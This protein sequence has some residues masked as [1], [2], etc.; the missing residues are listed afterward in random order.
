[1][2]EIDIGTEEINNELEKI[3]KS[4]ERVSEKS[5]SFSKKLKKDSI[6][7]ASVVEKIGK[8]PL[9]EDI[10]SLERYKK[11]V[12]E[13]RKEYEALFSIYSKLQNQSKG[14]RRNLESGIGRVKNL[15]ENLTLPIVE[16]VKPAVSFSD[17]KRID[18]NEI[19]NELRYAET[20]NKTNEALERKLQL[21]KSLLLMISQGGLNSE[22]YQQT[23]QEHGLQNDKLLNL[24]QEFRMVQ[25][26]RDLY[27]DI[28]R[29]EENRSELLELHKNDP[30]NEELA[31]KIEMMEISKSLTQQDIDDKKKILELFRKINELNESYE[32]T[33]N[34]EEKDAIT[35]NLIL[36]EEELKVLREKNKERQE[37]VEIIQ[38]EISKTEEMLK[39]F[40]EVGVEQVDTI[41]QMENATFKFGNKLKAALSLGLLTNFF[42]QLVKITSEFELQIVA[43]GAL[44]DSQNRANKLFTSVQQAALVSPYS[45]SEL[46]SYTK[47]LAAYRVETEDLTST[48]KMLGDIASGVG[49]DMSRLILVYGQ[50]KAANYLRG[51]ELRQFSEA[52]VNIL[53]ELA[54]YYSE[55]EGVRVSVGEVFERVSDR[56]V[57]FEDVQKVL[58]D[59]TSDGGLFDDMQRKQS[60]TIAGMMSNLKDAFQINMNEMGS[61]LNTLLKGAIK[62]VRFFVDNLK[63][64]TTVG[65][66]FVASKFGFYIQQMVAQARAAGAGITGF[67]NAFKGGIT[68]GLAGLAV[69]GIMGIANA[70]I[71]ARKRAEE[72][73]K[74]YNE[75]LTGTKEN[76][77][78]FYEVL[79]RLKNEAGKI[80]I[81]T[82][83]DDFVRIKEEVENLRQ[84]LYNQGLIIPVNFRNLNGKDIVSI[85]DELDAY[86]SF[87]AIGFR[88]GKDVRKNPLKRYANNI[89]ALATSLQN[90]E[91]LY[92]DFSQYLEGEELKK[93]QEL[94]KK[95]KDRKSGEFDLKSISKFLEN[96]RTIAGN[97][98][99]VNLYNI[100]AEYEDLMD[101]YFAVFTGENYI[102]KL[103][104]RNTTANLNSEDKETLKNN[105]TQYA[106]FIQS[107]F[108][109]AGVDVE[110]NFIKK[111]VLNWISSANKDGEITKELQNFV[112]N[113]LFGKNDLKNDLS[114]LQKE[115]KYS[116]DKLGSNFKIN[117]KAIM[118]VTPETTLEEG[119]KAF[120]EY[121]DKL[122]E[123]ERYFSANEEVK[124]SW[125]GR[126]GLKEDITKE[127][128]EKLLKGTDRDWIYEK[129]AIE[130]KDKKSGRGVDVWSE[131]ISS[132]IKFLKELYSEAEKQSKTFNKADVI[133]RVTE[134]FESGFE[135]MPEFFKQ[136]FEEINKISFDTPEGIVKAFDKLKSSVENLEIGAVK[137]G[138]FKRMIEEAVNPIELDITIDEKNIDKDKIFKEIDDLFTQYDL[139]KELEDLNIPR[140][141]TA[142]MF[143]LDISNF[144]ELF[145]E[146]TQRGV[147]LLN[148]Y[149]EDAAKEYKNV[150]KKLTDI[151]IKEQERRMKEYLKL[152]QDETSKRATIELEYLRK[153]QE[154]NS[155]NTDENTKLS[156]LSKVKET[157]KKELSELEW[158]TFKSSDLFVMLFDDLEHATTT[159]ID[160]ILKKLKE[161]KET[162]VLNNADANVISDI[163]KSINDLENIKIDRNPLKA[164]KE[165]RD[166]LIDTT[167][168]K[169]IISAKK[170]NDELLENAQKE[171]DNL[172]KEYE[173][174]EL[175]LKQREK[176][177]DVLDELKASIGDDAI[178]EDGLTSEEILSLLDEYE[179]NRKASDK[180][181]TDYVEYQN[182]IDLLYEYQGI[183]TKIN[184]LEAENSGI[185]S[186]DE[187]ELKGKV[188]SA[189]KTL[190][191]AKNTAKTLSD[192]QKALLNFSK[193][194]IEAL[195]VV[196]GVINNSYDLIGALGV[197]TNDLTDGWKDFM[198]T[199]FDIGKYTLEL[200]PSLIT[201]FTSA[202]VAINSAMGIIGLIAQAINLTI[203]M[204][205]V[206]SKIH[207]AN[208][209]VQIDSIKESADKLTKAFEKLDKAF[210]LAFDTEALNEYTKAMEQNLLTQ[211]T[212]LKNM[213]A[214]EKEK[215][216]S[217]EDAIKSWEE[218]ID[219]I[220]EQINEVGNKFLEEVGGLTEDAQKELANDFAEAWLSSFEEVGN[221]IQGLEETFDEFI[222]NV[223]LKQ[224]IQQGSKQYIQ[225]LAEM[226]NGFVSD[227][228]VS[229]Q[230]MNEIHD[231]WNNEI[232]DNLDAYY[233]SVYSLFENSVGSGSLSG[234]A[235]GI[236]GVTED[237]AQ[238]IESYMNSIRFFVAAKYDKIVNIENILTTTANNSIS[239]NLTLIA[240]NT[241]ALLTI[242]EATTKAGHPEGGTGFKVFIN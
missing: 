196:E 239:S 4:F 120:K 78:D 132:S 85:K 19:D 53:G 186:K 54:K 242:L 168:K 35:E 234:L 49:V 147:T 202:G 163:V 96:V 218:D 136:T 106:N 12:E 182:I 229:A 133:N 102:K 94:A 146:I 190:T 137:K 24:V 191:T 65:F 67:F 98:G 62:T 140:E 184:E 207:D 185:S 122:K 216:D 180:N 25:E 57:A 77:S 167:G 43:L 197:E 121:F 40:K 1:M 171:Y 21:E 217:D 7:I 118:T 172:L 16:S 232:R 139:F 45:V 165:L 236:Q 241:E 89:D 237:T 33:D 215:K 101:S 116:L 226:I 3:A 14:T 230:E 66:A 223:V 76:L 178:F 220:L 61:G 194:S 23:N 47:Q 71:T 70:M 63:T 75:L 198:N 5:K 110:D 152:L 150:E 79:E 72:F 119:Q 142:K 154:I 95:A 36:A 192:A 203:Q 130:E 176:S 18:E 99:Y 208:I 201:G 129:F 158:E 26:I 13:I 179:T 199:I 27:S 97:N 161:L 195:D 8:L 20:I 205:T 55:L 88:E 81:Q 68:G 126:L 38:E 212:Y 209:E 206:L 117:T 111:L 164:F 138:K 213:I 134:A 240:N 108:D 214:L 109:K 92:D 74:E 225:K 87:S 6:D 58:V 105:V 10:K 11:G 204:V 156:L 59:L 187:S 17:V 115:I 51:Q 233:Q 153:Q 123:Y 181:S 41:E 113:E 151:A 145:R 228:L 91:E 29:I 144:N 107:A 28:N 183:L 173:T 141:T 46:I 127:E 175:Y 235:S 149:G 189:E 135:E 83:S 84:E 39:S 44:V 34:I 174:L 64:V 188:D 56:R 124:K 155:L 82:D 128:V 131:R 30:E 221:G 93:F 52:G 210:G 157:Y 200:I 32:Q 114:L 2:A 211:I 238:I 48:L 193:Q 104:G 231:K 22:S 227:G 170:Y 80:E 125:L 112:N 169:S 177:G 86:G 69:A 42:R 224:L 100:N 148:E 73:N 60:Q 159:T 219:D 15:T 50:V 90:I 9:V 37:A 143:G 222:R 166:D 162:S 103:L 31:K 160:T